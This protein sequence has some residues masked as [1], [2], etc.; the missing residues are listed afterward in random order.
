M[1]NYCFKTE[2]YD[3]QNTAFDESR[4]LQNFALFMDMG[5]GK[6][7]VVL[8]TIG[9]AFEAGEI[10]LALIIAPKG[11]VPNWLSE[12]DTHLPDRIVRETVLWKPSLTKTKRAELNS[13]YEGD[14]KLR[15]LLMN[16]EAF[17][18]KKG[19]DVAKLFVEQFDTFMVVDE[20]TTIKNRQAKRTKALCA[21][22][23]D[24]DGESGYQVPSRS[25]QP[26]GI[27][28]PRDTGI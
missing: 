21:V 23:R 13:L 12:I 16:V 28:G 3:H 24:F 6:T 22:G 10:N 1:S 20:S 18:T 9:A 14:S 17:S 25:L 26:T 15:F 2:P 4:D 7:K 5:T 8:D 27:P 11:V 19:V